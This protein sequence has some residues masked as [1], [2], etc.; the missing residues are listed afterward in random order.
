M[1][2]SEIEDLKI[3]NTKARASLPRRLE[4]KQ[5][6][7]TAAGEGV[8]ALE[9]IKHGV[10]FGP[11]QGKKVHRSLVHDSRDTSYMW[12]VGRTFCQP[13]HQ[14]TDKFDAI[15]VFKYMLYWNST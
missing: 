3:S 8:F 5:S 9:E 6:N 11:Y 4:I 1:E 13:L 2:D 7:I 12:E 14:N 15:F 10:R